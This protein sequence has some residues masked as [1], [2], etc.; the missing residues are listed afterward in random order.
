VGFR[1]KVL[2]HT[3]RA[4]VP[5]SELLRWERRTLTE[6]L[7]EADFMTIH[8][9]LTPETY[10]L[11]GM[12]ELTQMRRSALLINTARGPIVDETALAAALRN[13]TIA[14]AGL[15]V[16]EQEPKLHPDLAR[17]HQVVLLPHLGSATL[18]TRTEMGMIC[19]KNV[20]AVLGGR[21][22]PNQVGLKA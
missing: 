16:F 4:I 14:G 13:G 2:Y 11:I 12:P 22:A 17:L 1:M 9:P 15:D 10:H 6:L 5:P 18:T 21:H 19:V 7:S 8:V 3:R 20:E